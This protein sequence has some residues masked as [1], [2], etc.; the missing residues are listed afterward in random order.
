MK[1][2]SEPITHENFPLF[3]QRLENAKTK[4]NGLK[5]RRFWASCLNVLMSSVLS[6]LV[7]CVICCT[8]EPEGMP[9]KEAFANIPEFFHK[10]DDCVM[11]LF[12]NGLDEIWVG[13]LLLMLIPVTGLISGLLF[14][15]LPIKGKVEKL[16]ATGTRAEQAEAASGLINRL[17]SDRKNL[18]SWNEDSVGIFIPAVVAGIA[19]L[20]LPIVSLCRYNGEKSILYILF[21]DIWALCS[22]LLVLLI[23]LCILCVAVF[24]LSWGQEWVTG[25]FY[26]SRSVEESF[27]LLKNYRELLEKEEEEQRKM[28][29]QETEDK[30]IHLLVSGEI[31]ASLKLLDLLGDEAKD[32]D[33]IVQMAETLVEDDPDVWTWCSWL[34]YDEEKINSEKLRTFLQNQKENSRQKLLELA[35]VEYP[36]ALALLDKKDYEGAMEYLK[37]ADAIDYQDGVALLALA[38]F[39]SGNTKVYAWVIERLTYGIEK[40]I[41]SEKLDVK[42]RSALNLAE[43][44]QREEQ[45]RKAA[46]KRAEDA[47]WLEVGRQMNMTCKYKQGDYCCWSCTLDNFPPLCFYRN[48]PRDMYMCD[49]RKR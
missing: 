34:D 31:S 27:E 37:A 17:R 29:L 36:K 42:C 26:R 24:Y 41:E 1:S 20:A 46:E 19:F 15:W 48:N 28:Q 23:V 38:S 43:I 22:I 40:G 4:M 14:R 5:K 25:L 30:A 49:K 44:Y 33:Y 13:L 2:K 45:E 39:E 16:E 10:I 6:A 7:V 3:I 11:G 35:E 9:M 21:G 47:Y 12:P 8:D 18:A 32:K